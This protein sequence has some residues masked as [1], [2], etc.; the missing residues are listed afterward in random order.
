[1]STSPVEARNLSLLS[2]V[3]PCLDEEL[4][5]RETH[6]R[7]TS[8]LESFTGLNFEIIYVDDGS[9]DSTLDILRELQH[10]D[11]RVRVISL[12]RNFGQFQALTAGM[13]HAAGDAVTLIDADLQDPPEVIPEMLERW[14]QGVDIVQGLRT[15]R[16]G[17]KRIK[18]WSSNLFLRIFRVAG[19]T[20]LRP[21]IGDFMIIDRAV[22]NSFLAMPET[23][24]Y[25]RGMISWLGYNHEI[26]PFERDARAAG[27]TKYSMKKLISLA[28]N[29]MLSFTIT[30]LRIV[31]WIGF[32]SSGLAFV[33]IIYTLAIRLFT[34]AWVPGWAI[35]FI[36]ILALNGLQF[37][38]LG[39]IGEYLGRTYNET[40]RR[41]LYLVRER[42][43]FAPADDAE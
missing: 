7:L 39:I 15:S 26:F 2:V 30:P 11:K 19:G 34:D 32:L 1:M 18:V 5:I 41:P 13:Q 38:F 21:G 42:L 35:I 24:R 40:K 22:L 9:Q 16:L 36:T 3:V 43:G 6:R 25:L 12:T 29:S 23:E 33:G 20:K 8:V 10:A 4:V 17:E 31:A 27:K 37:I 14:R 28:I